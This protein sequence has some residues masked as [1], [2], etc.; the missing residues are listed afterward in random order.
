MEDKKWGGKRAGAGRKTSDKAISKLVTLPTSVWKKIEDINNDNSAQ[1]N[2]KSIVENHF[3]NDNNSKN[4]DK[5]NINYD[6]FKSAAEYLLN[7]L[8][9]DFEDLQNV[10]LSRNEN[11]MTIASLII[12]TIKE[13]MVKLLLEDIEKNGGHWPD[14]VGI[15]KKCQD[16]ILSFTEYFGNPNTNCLFYRPNDSIMKKVLQ[17]MI[18]TGSKD[19]SNILDEI[20]YA[21]IKNMNN[22][23][24]KAQ[25]CYENSINNNDVAA[26]EE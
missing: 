12:R 10:Y 19:M 8:N 23:F 16:E 3:A 21:G 1:K 18:K 11:R 9:V 25:K 5:K 24:D 6:D 2:L 13:M 22:A 4:I 7:K 14:I 17:I 20:M 26:I 15:T